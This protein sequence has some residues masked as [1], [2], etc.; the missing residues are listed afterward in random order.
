[1]KSERYYTYRSLHREREYGAFWYS[2][3]WRALRPIL[4]GLCVAAVVAGLVSLAWK[5]VYDRYAAPVDSANDAIIAFEV[6]SG[7]SLTRVSKNLEEAGLI[8][9]ATVFKYYCDFAGLGQKL[10]SGHYQLNQTMEM[11]EIAERLTMGDGVPVVRNV[12]LIPGW[13]IENFAA[14][15][16]ERGV[17]A[18][19]SRFLELCRNG[20]S[21]TEY[22]YV[23]DAIESNGNQRIY[24][25]E[26]YLAANTYEVYINAPEEDIIKKLVSQ[27]DAL[28]S[29]EDEERAKAVLDKIVPKWKN[30]DRSALDVIF[31]MASMIEKEA[32]ETD[33]AKVAA[34]FYNRIS[35]GW[36]L[37]S[38]VTIHYITG[39]RKMNLTNADIS[40]DS[41]YN[42]YRNTGL[43]PG[44]I[45]SPSRKAIQAALYP[46]ENY[47][48]QGVMFF[49]AKEPSS[50]ELDFSV[51][52]E[53]HNRKVE[54]Y[55][56]SWQ[57][58]DEERGLQ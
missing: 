58:W 31:T 6:P 26:G 49:C 7:A 38:D 27:T 3:L 12:T 34:V 16:V 42:T 33:F 50:G 43:P 56:E 45:C 39:V 24:T 13:T 51:T 46:D 55:R 14:H 25:L 15:L 11:S 32:K 54:K 22:Y 53:E 57:R 36:T 4:I 41:P 9:S 20:E 29:D 21:F 44:P 2:W 37:D 35:N 17:I 23:K 19:S 10:Q 18:D 52:L 48:A 47:I 5:T 28:F 40:V 1:M 8:R 30:W